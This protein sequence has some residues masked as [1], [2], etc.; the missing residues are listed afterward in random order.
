VL[1]E[2]GG[3]VDADPQRVGVDVTVAVA[4]AL[5]LISHGE[6]DGDP[7]AE[8]DSESEPETHDRSDDA[9]AGARLQHLARA[10]TSQPVRRQLEPPALHHPC[11]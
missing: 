5:G 7:D 3:G 10:D 9:R 1:G 2:E 4:L 6:A 8:D 11:R